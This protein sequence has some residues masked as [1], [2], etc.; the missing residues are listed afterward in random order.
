MIVSFCVVAYNEQD[1]LPRLFKDIALQTYPH[2]MIEIVFVNSMSSDNTRFLMEQFKK[3]HKDFKNVI[4]VDNP[5]RNQASGW[6]MAIQASSGDLITRM[7]AHTS[8][9]ADFIRK[10][11]DCIKSGEDISG[12]PRPCILE[13]DTAWKRTLLLGENSMFGSSISPYRRSRG[14]KY[15]KSMF[16]ATYRSEVFEKVGGFNENL[17]RTEDNEIHYRMRKAG[18]QFCFSPEIISYQYIRKNLR[19]MIKQKFENGYWIG[20]TVGVSPR[21]LSIFHFVPF[22]FLLGIVLTSLLSIEGYPFLGQLMWSLYG[23]LAIVMSFLAID[24]KNFKIT[25]FFLP[26]LF[27]LLHVSYGAGTLAGLLK[28]PF[29]RRPYKRK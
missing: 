5:K 18:Y 8:V 2:S 20:L 10:N 24:W 15:V 28:M 19:E 6:N 29:W 13:D 1:Y 27:L 7:D 4:I 11:V 23:I 17:G 26:V 9:P 16:H 25:Y 21:C 3:E 14:K 12:G 22:F